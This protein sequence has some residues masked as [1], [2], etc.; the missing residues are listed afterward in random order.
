[1]KIPIEYYRDCAELELMLNQ[2]GKD[3]LLKMIEYVQTKEWKDDE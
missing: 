1:M 3:A 2:Y